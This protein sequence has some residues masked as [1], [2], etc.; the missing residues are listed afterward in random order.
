MSLPLRVAVADDELFMRNYLQKTLS[1]MGHEVVAAAP[2]GQELIEQ[3]RATSPDLVIVD[4]EMPG[5]DGL[6]AAAE[7][8]RER[9]IPIIVITAYHSSDYLQRARQSHIA[10]YLVKPIKRADLETVVKRLACR[11][12]PVEAEPISAG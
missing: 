6:S 8:Y 12:R 11:S 3:C 9:P 1:L 5:T 7:I 4:V 10:A 2:N